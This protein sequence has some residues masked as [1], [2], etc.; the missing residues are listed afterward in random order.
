MN[1]FITIAKGIGIVLENNAIAEVELSPSLLYISKLGDDIGRRSLNSEALV[2]LKVRSKDKRPTIYFLCL[3]NPALTIHE[4]VVLYV[5]PGSLSSHFNRKH[6]SKLEE[7]GQS[8]Y[9]MYDVKLEHRQYLQNHVERFY[10]TV[11]RRSA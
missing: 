10:R 7:W 5:T 1:L 4:R 11:L 8:I 6:V 2:R 3:R 9:W